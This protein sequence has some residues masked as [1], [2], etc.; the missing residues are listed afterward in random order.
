MSASIR[1]T[2]QYNLPQK[3]ENEYDGLFI[4]ILAHLFPVNLTI[5]CYYAIKITEALK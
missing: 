1:C 4:S 5:Q 3:N 2:L